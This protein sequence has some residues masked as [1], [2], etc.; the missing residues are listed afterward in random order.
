[1]SVKISLTTELKF[2]VIGKPLTVHGYVLDFLFLNG[3]LDLGYCFSNPS[4]LSTPSSTSNTEYLDS[5]GE[6]ISRI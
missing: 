4:P 1:M 2:K 5:K 6:A 3:S